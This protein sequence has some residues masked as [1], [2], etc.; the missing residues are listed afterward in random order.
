MSELDPEENHID[1]VSFDE[2]LMTNET[3]DQSNFNIAVGSVVFVIS[4]VIAIVLG[5]Y[6]K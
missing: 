3:G 5:L 2:I 6:F 4:F 1:G